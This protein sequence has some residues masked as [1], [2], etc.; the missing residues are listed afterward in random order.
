[1][2]LPDTTEVIIGRNDVVSGFYPDIDL[3]SHGGIEQG[4]GRRHMR[5][6]LQQG[7]VHAEDLDSTN[8]TFVNGFRLTAHRSHALSS[9]DE[10]RL[11]NLR[12]RIRF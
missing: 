8:G 10:L 11:G 3:T 12:L 5:L 9:G 6:L 1:V 4:V 2:P 7:Q